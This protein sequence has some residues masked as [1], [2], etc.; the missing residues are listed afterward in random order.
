V[1]KLPG[2]E[3]AVPVHRLDR[4]TSGVCLFARQPTSVEALS[5][6][7]THGQKTYLALAQGTLHKRG[8][9]RR[10]LR[11]GTRWVE[12]TTRYTLERRVGTHSLVRVHPENGRKHQIRRHLSGLGHPVLGD[13]RY[14][15]PATN[16]FFE[17]RHGLDRTFLHC[18]QIVLELNGTQQT[19]TS[20]LSADL[21]AVIASLENS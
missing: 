13:E 17:E 4:D 3:Q 11:D 1:R 9:I 10:K 20:P 19:L 2:C 21:L 7:L 14:G 15:K 12:A 6:A 8:I 5:N 16:R 18:Q